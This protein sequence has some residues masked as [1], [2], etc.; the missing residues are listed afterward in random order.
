MLRRSLLGTL[1]GSLLTRKG[2]AAVPETRWRPMP[3]PGRAMQ[4][5]G[6]GPTGLLAVNADGALLALSAQGAPARHLA[7]GIDPEAPIATGHGRIAA[8]RA[9]GALWVLDQGRASASAEQHLARHAG[10]MVL[11]LAVIVVESDGR[12]HRAARYEPTQDGRW[13]GI[14]RSQIDLLPDARPL[15][16]DL[17]GSGDGGHVVL[18]A[19]PDGARYPHGVLGDAIEPTRIVLLERHSLEPMRELTLVPPHVFEDIAPRRVMLAGRDGL[20]TVRA[21]PQGGQLVLVDADPARPGVL[22]IA[23]QGEPLGTANRW[24][25]P[26]VA[27]SQWLAVHTPHIGGVLQAY[28]HEGDRLVARRLMDGVSNHRIGSRTLDQSARVGGQL[29][30]PTQSGRGVR[31]VD[32]SGGASAPTTR[33][34]PGRIDALVTL[35]PSGPVAAL[36]DDGS[37]LVAA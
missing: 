8:R 10:M 28:R 31:I 20:L 21:G 3:M 19:G 22:R 2:L 5:A 4:I 32:P 37:V 33:E 15:Q 7:D 35:E 23:A 29:W 12:R 11:P 36:L 14:A 1:I 26:I 6:G 9:D 34:I 18:L 24:M 25:S 30:L 16:A 17:D 27:G 13:R